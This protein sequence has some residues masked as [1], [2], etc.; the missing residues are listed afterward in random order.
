MEVQYHKTAAAGKWFTLSLLEQMAHIGSEVGR[1]CQ[2][3][4]KDEKLFEEAR[5]RALELFDLTMSSP[6]LL[7]R[8]KEIG[9]A[10]EL[11]CFA[12]SGNN[13]YKTSL[14]D[15]DNYFFQFALAARTNHT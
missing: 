15:L 5:E 11:F 1:A 6:R 7:G 4:G 10:R 12:A 8:L 3:Q 14:E 13:A 2:W 9:R